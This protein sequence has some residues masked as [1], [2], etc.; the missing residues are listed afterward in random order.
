MRSLLTAV[1]VLAA[2]RIPDEHF[3]GIT[4][5]G[6]DSDGATTDDAPPVTMLSKAWIVDQ[7]SKLYFVRK[8]TD[9]GLMLSSVVTNTNSPQSAVANKQGTH[10]FV[11]NLNA[12]TGNS[13]TDFVINTDGTLTNPST[14]LLTVGGTD[15]TPR[16]MAVHPGGRHLAV[17]C[18]NSRIATVTLDANGAM[19]ATSIVTHTAVG[20]APDN[21]VF[22]PDGAC[23]FAVDRQAGNQ[24][25]HRLGFDVTAG[26]ASV[27]AT[28]PSSANK[29][30]AMH[31]S[32]Q[33]LYVAGDSS[34][35]MHRVLP[36]CGLMLQDTETIAGTAAGNV[37]IVVAPDGRRL[38]VS[39]AGVYVYDVAGDGTMNQL[40]NSPMLNFIMIE[41]STMDASLPT[42][43]YVT[44][45]ADGVIPVSVDANGG[46]TGGTAIRPS[47]SG[48][49][50][51]GFAMA[52]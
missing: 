31:P 40:P 33:Y 15:C 21:L 1:V 42:K 16:Y 17:G 32:G 48:T 20:L 19:S 47:G 14:R 24:T 22:T 10:L 50:F 8:A 45:R 28:T 3:I 46:L 4:G 7:N 23:L 35:Q 6:G 12:A 13:I 9:G 52:P 38:F 39:T 18:S 36:G 43:L 34:V 41:A 26:S 51:V 2:C 49:N 5:D 37:S 11:A 30:I 44:S 27:I 25:L 29:G